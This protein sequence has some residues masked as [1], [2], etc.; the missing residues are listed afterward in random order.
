MPVS[1]L[2]AGRRMLT[3]DVFALTT[4]VDRQ[5][6][7]RTPRA[8]RLASVLLIGPRALVDSRNVSHHVSTMAAPVRHRPHPARMS[9][10]IHPCGV[11]HQRARL[12]TFERV[13]ES[14]EDVERLRARLRELEEQLAARDTAP[15]ADAP[16]SRR[17][18]QWWRSIVVTV[19]I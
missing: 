8:P 7:S 12:T 11:R 9:R 2:M 1:A 4:S 6:T 10:G 14:P 5:V 3:A 19:L 15:V 13:T 17:D 16:R 18:R